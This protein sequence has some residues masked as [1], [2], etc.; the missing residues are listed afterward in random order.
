MNYLKIFLMVAILAI[1]S[2]SYA[3]S[4]NC[5]KASTLVEKSICSEKRLSDLDDL[6]VQSYKKA[7]SNVTDKNT[8]KMEQRAWLKNSRNKC[9]TSD[10]LAEAYKERI[11]ALN[12]STP[13]GNEL[14][15]IVLGRCQMNE[16][17][18]WKVEKS[19]N[20]KSASNGKLV[21]VYVRDAA[22]EFPDGNYPDVFPQS[23]NKRWSKKVSEAFVFCSPKLPTY[24]EYN[25]ETKK[26]TGTIPFSQDGSTSGA[27]EGI[28]NLYSYVCGQQS[29]FEINPELE[30]SEINIGKPTDIFNYP[31][32]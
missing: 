7:S 4:F 9:Q 12:T 6:L 25:E 24:I 27:T 16:C 2:E 13:Q 19:E 8:L 32:K 21:K 26:F 11:E 31:I 1:T 14:K 5:A 18:W 28:G 20:I 22:I 17:W 30:F 3:V 23:E 15:N 10:C 29:I